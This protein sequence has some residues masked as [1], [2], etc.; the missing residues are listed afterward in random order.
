MM[1]RMISDDGE[2]DSKLLQILSIIDD[3]ITID[4]QIYLFTLG[5]E[6]EVTADGAL[7]SVASMSRVESYSQNIIIIISRIVYHTSGHDIETLIQ[8]SSTTRYLVPTM[9]LTSHTSHTTWSCL[10]RDCSWLVMDDRVGWSL[11]PVNIMYAQCVIDL[12]LFVM[13]LLLS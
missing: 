12:L 10:R 5:A 13:F 4:Q 3:I 9:G 8:L 6:V 7:V 2:D 11:Y 1:V